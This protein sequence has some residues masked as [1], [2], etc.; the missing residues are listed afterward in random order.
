[1]SRAVALIKKDKLD[2]IEK[3][4]FIHE[5]EVMSKLDHPNILRLYERLQDEKRYYL[6]SELCT[7][8]ELYDEIV[9]KKKMK[10]EDAA[11]IIL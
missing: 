6:I 5:T 7:G 9:G 11:E 10:E 3:K 2:A 8:G 1:M 4:R